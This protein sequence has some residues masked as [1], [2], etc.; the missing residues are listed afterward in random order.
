LPIP[1]LGNDTTICQGDSLLLDVSTSGVTFSWN[2]GATTGSFMVDSA[3]LYTVWV[4]N[5]AGC[6][7]GD[8]VVV[9]LRALPVVNLG[10]DARICSG[11]GMGLV[12]PPLP[13]G[14]S[15]YTYLWSTGSTSDSIWV[16]VAGD[17]WVQ[18]TDSLGCMED[19]SLHLDVTALPIVS[20]GLL[21]PEY[22]LTDPSV[23]LVGSPAGGTWSG[24][25]SAAGV[26]DPTA[27]GAGGHT[28][29][30]AY[31]DS[32]GCAGADTQATVVGLPPS[33]ALA[34][35]DQSVGTQAVLQAG[36]PAVGTG[37]WSIGN[38]PG[39]FSGVNSPDAVAVWDES[40]VYPFVWT[41][42]NAPCPP[43]SDTVWITFEGLHVPTGFSPNGDGMNDY[44]VIRGLGS[45]PG[46]KLD[47]FNRWGN[48]VWA[49]ADYQ[50]EWNGGNENGNPLVEDTYYAVLEYGGKRVST[51]IVLER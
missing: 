21:L 40:G 27:V 3:G 13:V 7:A 34:G 38:F 9:G 29:V 25:T 41:V 30:Y 49:S 50:G 28:V 6:S 44:Y 12:A 26:F 14:G 39:L 5:S 33:P 48:V 43:V 35:G 17:Y 46:A 4:T 51:F 36:I 11:D 42:E 37:H 16:T 18:V 22:C 10:A 24:A 2:T 1:G 8:S 47:V 20:F 31:T 45:F 19:D 15:T 23:A 32:L